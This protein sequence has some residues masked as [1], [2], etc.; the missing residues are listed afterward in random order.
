[1]CVVPDHPATRLDDTSVPS[2]PSDDST[3]CVSTGRDDPSAVVVVPS[4][5]LGFD[6]VR[7]PLMPMKPKLGSDPLPGE[8]PEGRPLLTKIPCERPVLDRPTMVPRLSS[9]GSAREMGSA[10]GIS[11]PR[12]VVMER[13][14]CAEKRAASE[15]PLMEPAD[16]N[17]QLPKGALHAPLDTKALVD[18]LVQAL[19]VS[20]DL[21]GMFKASLQSALDASF[22]QRLEAMEERLAASSEARLVCCVEQWEECRTLLGKLSVAS[23][24]AP[25]QQQPPASVMSSEAKM[26][27]PRNVVVKEDVTIHHEQILDL[28]VLIEKER[29]KKGRETAKPV[30]EDGEAQPMTLDNSHPWTECNLR[31]SFYLQQQSEDPTEQE[32]EKQEEDEEFDEDGAHHHPH[33]TRCVQFVREIVGDQSK[34]SCIYKVSNSGWFHMFGLAMTAANCLLVAIDADN[35]VRETMQMALSGLPINPPSTPWWLSLGQRLFLAW[36]SVETVVTALG[37]RVQFFFGPGRYWNL[38]DTCILLISLFSTFEAT[39]A[40]ADVS[41][42]RVLRVARGIRALRA[43]RFVRYS[44]PLQRMMG[45]ALSVA[46]SLFWAACVMFIFLYIVGITMLEGVASFLQGQDASAA[47][48]E[49]RSSLFAGVAGPDGRTLLQSLHTF[50]GSLWRTIVTL[51]RGMTG[52][53]WGA[54]ACPLNAAGWVYGIIWVLFIFISIFGI[55]SVVTAVIVNVM[56]RPL[57]QDQAVRIAADAKETRALLRMF[58]VEARKCGLDSTIMLSKTKFNRFVRSPQVARSLRLFGVDILHVKDAF[59]L[60]DVDRVGAVTLKDAAGRFMAFRGDARSLDITRLVAEVRDIRKEL[61]SVSHAC[62][63]TSFMVGRSSM[64][65]VSSLTSYL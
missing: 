39:S 40:A 32:E 29:A 59:E 30:E 57:P 22:L 28:D 21:Q 52:A 1:M 17:T 54:L 49:W 7:A 24:D 62:H 64:N 2:S 27:T 11:K 51:L 10:R 44:E 36:L 8:A 41:F 31:D 18:D 6:G 46:L 45:S 13:K 34:T 60:V 12:E 65:S 61:G 55:L 19:A 53:D 3:V 5:N 38:F 37:E 16:V 25:Q 47:G 63:E 14:M 9:R 23:Q 48:D 50:Y 33:C 4:G 58:T 35:N 26:G 56:H 43:V 42:V 20:L 15:R